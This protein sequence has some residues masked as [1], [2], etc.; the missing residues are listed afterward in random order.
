MDTGV[1]AARD[2]FH[3]TAWMLGVTEST[4]LVDGQ[5]VESKSIEISGSCE[6]SARIG[7]L[8]LWY[9]S[10]RVDGRRSWASLL[11]CTKLGTKLGIKTLATCFSWGFSGCVSKH[12]IIHS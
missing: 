5:C 7:Q 6:V 10:K 8:V 4:V 12:S 1:L 11:P 3:K 9:G 2:H